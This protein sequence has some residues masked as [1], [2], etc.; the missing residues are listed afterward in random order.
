M[1]GSNKCSLSTEER[2]KKKQALV[3]QWKN[4]DTLKGQQKNNNQDCIK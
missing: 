2:E 4:L 1:G 3:L